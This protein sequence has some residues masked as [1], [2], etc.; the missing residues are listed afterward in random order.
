MTIRMA[1]VGFLL[2]MIVSC[3]VLSISLIR[4]VR[5]VT[6]VYPPYQTLNSDGT[7]GGPAVDLVRCA[8]G[9]AGKFTMTYGTN[10]PEIQRDVRDGRAE[11]FF[12]ALKT[13]EREK[14]ATR[15]DPI[16]TAEVIRVTMRNRQPQVPKRIAIKRGA[17]I[18]DQIKLM[19]GDRFTTVA[20][21]NNDDLI[22][23]LIANEA[24]MFIMDGPV[25]DYQVFRL[26][27]SMS[28]F[29]VAPMIE[30]TY[31]VYFSKTFVMTHPQYLRL[32]NDALRACRR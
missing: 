5:Y 15:S 3:G 14:Y 4:P 9:R 18:S 1:L 7:I 20:Y 16:A 28:L 8:A 32:F 17:G 29:N 2:S 6:Q 23:A 24:D 25:F 11:A 19:A 13:D 12:G 21:D 10:W 27:R 22:E 30:E 26:G 31:G